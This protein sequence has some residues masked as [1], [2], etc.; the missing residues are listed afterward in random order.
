[1][2][3]ESGV[4][5]DRTFAFFLLSEPGASLDLHLEDEC[6]LRTPSATK[7][8]L[9]N[10]KVVRSHVIFQSGCQLRHS[11]TWCKLGYPP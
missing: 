1:M 5:L 2:K 9:S 8:W 6:H 4:V 10:D 3:T 7:D 11:E